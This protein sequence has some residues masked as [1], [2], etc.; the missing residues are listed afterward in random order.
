[1]KVLHVIPGVA[2]RTG[3]PATA[4]LE[5]SRVL[6]RH[7]VQCTVMTTDLGEAASAPRHTRI[8][9]QDRFIPRDAEIQMFRAQPPRRIA[10]SVPLARAIRAIV[11]DYDVVHIHSLFLFPQYA[12]Y[13][14]ASRA[15]VQFIVSPCGA[16]DPA[17]RHRSRLA[18]AVTDIVWQRRMLGAAAAIHFKTSE[19]QRLAAD[20]PLAETQFVVPNG[21]DCASF[22]AH[23]GNERFRSRYLRGCDGPVILN[24][25]RLSHKKGLDVLI[26]AFA[27]VKRRHRAALLVLAGPDDEGLTPGLRTLAAEAGVKE[28]VVFTGMLRAD[29]LRAALSAASVWALPSKTENFGNAVIE[30]MAAGVPIVISPE[31]N[32]A[33][34]VEAARAGIICD[35]EPREVANALAGLLE[36]D[37]LRKSYAFE[38][39][40]FAGRFDWSRVA[41]R[42]VAMYRSVVGARRSQL[43]NEG[44]FAT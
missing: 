29:E 17:L 27:D 1:V 8:T 18:K 4:V 37:D 44:A 10:F 16:L 43:V 30:A 20:L 35:R 36:D 19:E 31:V 7:G 11:F 6:S 3:G 9:P 34:E 2:D 13:K 12:A 14:A 28:S 25:G 22:H 21:I 41:P 33:S 38:G 40:K 42:H 24:V 32:V 15:G 39:R 5:S 23:I 26:R